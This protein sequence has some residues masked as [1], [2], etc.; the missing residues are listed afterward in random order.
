MK[1]RG[2]AWK[3]DYCSKKQQIFIILCPVFVHS[4]Y[5]YWA[6]I[7]LSIDCRHWEKE[8]SKFRTNVQ[9]TDWRL[10][11]PLSLFGLLLFTFAFGLFL[12]VWFFFFVCVCWLI[13]CSWQ[14]HQCISICSICGEQER[15]WLCFQWFYKLDSCPFFLLATRNA[16]GLSVKADWQRTNWLCPWWRDDR[17]RGLYTLERCQ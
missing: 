14:T 12:L 10:K 1:R 7:I 3:S 13:I 5:F 2:R 4:N 17:H 8:M 9:V 16:F 11:L 15:L 6:E